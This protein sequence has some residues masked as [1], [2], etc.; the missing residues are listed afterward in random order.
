VDSRYQF[1]FPTL[2]RGKTELITGWPGCGQDHRP[3]FGPKRFGFG[4]RPQTWQRWLVVA[5]FIA[6]V[7]IIGVSSH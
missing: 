2:Q 7:A 1:G 3:W 6:V 4:V 5:V